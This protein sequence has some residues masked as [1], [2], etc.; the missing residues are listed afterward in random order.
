[1]N[2]PPEEDNDVQDYQTP[3]KHHKKRHHHHRVRHYRINPF[4]VFVYVVILALG[5]L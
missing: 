2:T 1:M 4:Y 5:T 3:P